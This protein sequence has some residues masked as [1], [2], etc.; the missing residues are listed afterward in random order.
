MSSAL[1]TDPH[2]PDTTLHR[3][4]NTE[5]QR[6]KVVVKETLEKFYTTVW[7]ADEIHDDRSREMLTMVACEPTSE[8]VDP[9]QIFLGKHT[10]IKIVPLPTNLG[11]IRIVL[12]T[13]PF[14]QQ[15]FKLR[16]RI[17]QKESLDFEMFYFSYD[18]MV[19][20][21]NNHYRS[22]G[23][24]LQPY[25]LYLAVEEVG[26]AEQSTFQ[27]IYT[28]LTS[29]LPKALQFLGLQKPIGFEKESKLFKWTTSGNFNTSNIGECSGGA[30]DMIKRF[31][32]IWYRDNMNQ[33][34][35]RAISTRRSVREEAFRFFPD[36][37]IIYSTKIIKWAIKMLPPICDKDAVSSLSAQ[38]EALNLTTGSEEGAG[39][40]LLAGES[41]DTH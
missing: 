1:P 33:F 6:M 38:V 26:V 34:Q 37:E 15:N 27:D 31:S 13:L 18:E 4:P 10:A 30:G 41:D 21:L 29:S 22:L 5:Y 9:W 39:N 35:D 12:F 40:G 28:N 19:R 8:D 7:P 16:L 2:F 3:L 14:E 24:Y 36:S 11:I 23:L 32:D 25:G 17:C 20:L